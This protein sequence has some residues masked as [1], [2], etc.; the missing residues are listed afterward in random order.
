MKKHILIVLFVTVATICQAQAPQKGNMP[1]GKVYMA[2]VWGA[3]S[4]GETDSTASIQRAVDEIS[5]RGGGSL[6]FTVGRYLT[7]AIELKDNVTIN[8]G[9]GAVLVGSVNIYDYKG[10]PALIWANGRK[11]VHIHGSGTVEGRHSCLCAHINSQI[12]RGLLPDGFCV[13][14]LCS[15]VNCTDSDI[16]KQLNMRDDTAESFK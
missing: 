1:R 3:R 9:R 8:I 14:D 4:D 2:T 11:N 16:S 13:P 6:I 12:G 5:A 15:L 10:A 7:G